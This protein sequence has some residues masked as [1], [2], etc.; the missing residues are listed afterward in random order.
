MNKD[1]IHKYKDKTIREITSILDVSLGFVSKYKNE[2]TEPSIRVDN[3]II[4]AAGVGSRL[5]PLTNNT[6][7]PLLLVNDKPIIEHTIEMLIKNQ[8]PKIIIVVGHLANKFEYLK[9]KYKCVDLVFNGNY[10]D[11][12]NIESLK[13][14]A[15]I[16]E[17]TIFVEGD[18]VWKED[19]FSNKY[20]DSLMY[21]WR[22]NE[23]TSE[24]SFKKNGKKLINLTKGGVRNSHCWAGT[25]FMKAEDSNKVRDFFKTYS[26]KLNGHM[27]AE[28]AFWKEK[29]QF[30]NIP[31][32]KNI[33]N[34]VDTIEEYMALSGNQPTE[35]N[36]PADAITFYMNCEISDIKNLK[37]IKGGL[38]ND[39]Y[40]FIL[41]EKKYFLRM[42]RQETNK[43]ISRTS[44]YDVIEGI[45]S[46][47]I[48]PTKITFSQET[49]IAIFE[50]IENNR[51]LNKENID[52]LRSFSKVLS[53]LH[54]AK[55]K[56]G[57]KFDPIKG[58]KIYSK[59][60]DRH[61]I[62]NNKY[63]E[64]YKSNIF[65]LIK[66]IY[67]LENENFVTT[68]ND[69]L[70]GNILFQ[71]NKPL[72]IDW[73]YGAINHPYWDLASFINENELNEE[74]EEVFLKSYGN[75][76]RDMLR[77]FRKI[78]SFYW[79]FWTFQHPKWE[80]PEKN[81]FNRNISVLR[82]LYEKDI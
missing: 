15:D 64:K 35:F 49:G 40:S 51:F 30:E 3:A 59:A 23:D 25:Y 67:L 76:Q 33:F 12:N 82:E 74:Q 73:E 32:Q 50:Y 77:K 66:E 63:I 24:W 52:D 37:S 75:V 17:N 71:N 13:A 60:Y 79:A 1:L 44:E 69:L 28:E 6:P 46:L 72:I 39:S 2:T 5:K 61:K 9:E 41:D 54:N 42:T 56:C 68:H 80:E 78:V 34:E 65:E 11:F 62:G 81:Y 53:T 55:L 8:I 21:S 47:N 10:K 70:N 20:S 4:F 45:K 36:N 57:E 22:T 18:V 26:T 58:F 16:I 38:T 27:F 48:S 19:I 29:I 7:K 43:N 14:V 31:V